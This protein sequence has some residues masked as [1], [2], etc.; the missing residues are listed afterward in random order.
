MIHPDSFKDNLFERSK[1]DF[2]LQA[3]EL[4]RYQAINCAPYAR[5]IQGL[6]LHPAS[7]NRFEDIPYLPIEAFKNHPIQS[8]NF[9][10]EVIF[11]SSGTTGNQTSR[12]FV[13]DAKWY[14][15]VFR[16]SFQYAYGNPEDFAWLGLLPAYLERTGSSL[17]TMVDSFIQGSP[18]KQSGFFLNELSELRNRIEELSKNDVPTILIGVSFALLDFAEMVDT[19][20]P[21]NVIVM[22]TGGMKGRRKEMVRAELHE[23]LKSGF[24][25][26]EIHS[27]YGM[28][29]LMSQA[30]SKG[31]GLYQSP[32]WMK[33][34]LRD[35]AD[36]LSGVPL[37][38]TGGINI[39]DLANVDSCAFIATQD[40][41]RLHDPTT[42]E[43]LGRFDDSDIRGCN[44]MVQ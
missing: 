30:Y 26:S 4:F 3:L 41:G 31:N 15:D 43:V 9:E 36:P 33:I 8:G 7:V 20:L 23:V 35:P 40:L 2:E 22:E 28:T 34:S 37:G 12:H 17:V 27:E 25:P 5:F 21:A 32:P 24:G 44:L 29:E 1:S 16:A 10:P 39:A 14:T 11:T 42:F 18:H 38:K 19:S 6:G 13:K